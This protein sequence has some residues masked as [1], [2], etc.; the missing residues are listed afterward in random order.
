[1]FGHMSGGGGNFLINIL[2]SQGKSLKKN[3]EIVW[4]LLVWESPR[5]TK[6]SS[7]FSLFNFAWI[8]NSIPTQTIRG[9]FFLIKNKKPKVVWEAFHK[10]NLQMFPIFC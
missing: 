8:S 4:F 2:K 9:S 6:K 7:F 3:Q 1:M 10:N 5:V